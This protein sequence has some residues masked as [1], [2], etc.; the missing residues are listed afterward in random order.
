VMCN[1][2]CIDNDVSLMKVIVCWWKCLCT[3]L[4]SVWW[5]FVDVINRSKN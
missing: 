1:Y 2:I 4:W 3:M 5:G